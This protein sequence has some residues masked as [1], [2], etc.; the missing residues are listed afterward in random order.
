MH[1]ETAIDK[2]TVTWDGRIPPVVPT[3]E[4]V[5]PQPVEYR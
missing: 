5:A 1:R 2:L 3:L 4:G